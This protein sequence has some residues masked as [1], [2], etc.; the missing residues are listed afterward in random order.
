MYL[1][2]YETGDRG[3]IVIKGDARKG[4]TYGKRQT[5]I[6]ENRHFLTLLFRL[7]SGRVFSALYS[8]NGGLNLLVEELSQSRRS[9]R[10]GILGRLKDVQRF[11]RD[12]GLWYHLGLL[13]RRA[14][15]RRQA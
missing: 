1:N 13:P 9:Q 5:R 4:M 14:R 2:R 12:N 3:R 8:R 11:T 10:R 7:R 15:D 6:V